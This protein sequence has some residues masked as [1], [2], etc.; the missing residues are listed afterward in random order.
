M[1]TEQINTL[2][3][4]E[5]KERAFPDFAGSETRITTAHATVRFAGRTA[6][7]LPPALEQMMEEIGPEEVMQGDGGDARRRDA[8]TEEAAAIAPRV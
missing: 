7:E 2:V 4:R 1:T 5:L 6:Q 8:E 3:Q